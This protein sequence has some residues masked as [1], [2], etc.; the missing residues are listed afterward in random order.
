MGPEFH[1][2]VSLRIRSAARRATSLGGVEPLG[3]HSLLNIP[4]L[5]KNF[6][7]IHPIVNT[8]NENLVRGRVYVQPAIDRED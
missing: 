8:H 5:G 7:T 1:L 2:A 4:T 6:V 3:T